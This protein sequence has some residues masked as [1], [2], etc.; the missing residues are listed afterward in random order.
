MALI[1]QADGSRFA[2]F[3]SRAAP[4]A[5]VIEFQAAHVCVA[6]LGDAILSLRFGKAVLAVE[7]S[8]GILCFRRCDSRRLGLGGRGLSKSLRRGSAEDSGNDDDSRSF[9]GWSVLQIQS[10]NVYGTL[11]FPK[12]SLSQ[13]CEKPALG[14]PFEAG[15]K[16]S[17][18][19]LVAL[20]R[21]SWLPPR[22]AAALLA[23]L[24]SEPRV[25]CCQCCHELCE[26]FN[27]EGQQRNEAQQLLTK[28][29][30]T[31]LM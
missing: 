14:G 12:S 13:T 21:H 2:V 18:A 6:R 22:V 8:V 29:G 24:H 25:V 11:P 27:H 19:V 23:L 10:P 31:T 20:L 17:V 16:H 3:C 30:R 7:G 15:A 26:Q 1:I 9:H 4:D 5:F 28:T